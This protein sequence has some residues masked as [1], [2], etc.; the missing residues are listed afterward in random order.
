MSKD[1]RVPPRRSLLALPPDLVEALREAHEEQDMPTSEPAAEPAIEQ[2]TEPVPPEPTELEPGNPPPSK[3]TSETI[4][5][6][7]LE[8]IEK[9]LETPSRLRHRPPTE[10]LTLKKR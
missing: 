8:Q 1:S 10:F 5:G 9:Q 4:T 3:Q 7:T 2:P 6:L